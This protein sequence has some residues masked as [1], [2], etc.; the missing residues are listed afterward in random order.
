MDRG[1]GGKEMINIE[2][3]RKQYNRWV[4]HTKKHGKKFGIEIDVNG[5]IP[6]AK[7]EIEEILYGKF[8][9]SERAINIWRKQGHSVI[10]KYCKFC[11]MEEKN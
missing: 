3:A 4:E 11:Q 1:N 9:E 10:P 6:E 2:R 5:L 7:R 8:G